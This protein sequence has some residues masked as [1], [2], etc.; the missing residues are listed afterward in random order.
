MLNRYILERIMVT[1][2][3][4][5]WLFIQLHYHN[6]S[7]TATYYFRLHRTSP[8]LFHGITVPA[9]PMTPVMNEGILHPVMVTECPG[10]KSLKLLEQLS[11]HQECSATQF[12]AN[13]T[14]SYGNYIVDADGNRL[15][16]LYM[17][18]ASLP[19][20]YN[21]PT[22]LASHSDPNNAWILA[23]RPAL[24]VLPPMEWINMLQNGLMKLAP[25]GMDDCVTMTCGSTA[26][27]NA[28]KAIF[29]KYMNDRRNGYQPSQKDLN[30]CM[31]NQSPGSP[32][33]SILSFTGGFPHL[34]SS[35]MYTQQSH[36][37]A[38]HTLVWL[39]DCSFP[40][41]PLPPRGE[42]RCQRTWR[43]EVSVRGTGVVVETWSWK[44]LSY[45]RHDHRT[46]SGRRRW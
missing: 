41:H 3:F 7:L 8:R 30:S 19:L 42:Y 24:G 1:S 35:C 44:C 6:K 29:I 40:Q 34:R 14:K 9:T 37:K 17:Q 39:A 13:Y 5:L 11:K 22:I 4:I 33:L 26:N 12:F 36:T 28:F 21:H 25:P 43:G 45:R 23:N 10:P 18:I 38:R 27:E 16:D 32:R 20:G 2:R 46:H 15:L 31:L